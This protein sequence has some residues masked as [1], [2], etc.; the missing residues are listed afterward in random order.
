MSGIDVIY[1]DNAATSFPKPPEV[2]EAI[3]E[4]LTHKAGNPGRSGHSLAVAAAAVV[5][6]TRRSLASLLGIRDPSR[7]VFTLNATDALNLAMY[8][9]LRPGDRVVTTS[10]EH[11]A[12]ARPLFALA[13]R[14]VEVIRLPCAPDG[15]LDLDDLDR[16][17]RSAPTRLVAMTHASNVCGTILPI[18]AAAELA[19]RRGALLLVDAAQTAGVLPIDVTEQYSDLRACPGQKGR[20]GPTGTGGLYV[21]PGVHLTPMRQGGT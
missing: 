7:L 12:V 5:A 16:E 1:L 10:M 21:A 13:E 15:S 19:H 9:L 20:L 18:S 11:N 4:F 8:G 3:L 6:E 14:G 2:G 17:L